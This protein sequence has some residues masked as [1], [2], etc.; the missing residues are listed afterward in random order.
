VSDIFN[1]L[2]TEDLKAQAAWE[3]FHSRITQMAGVPPGRP[4]ETINKMYPKMMYRALQEPGSG[5]WKVSMDIPPRFQYQTDDQWSRAVAQAEQFGTACQRTV[6]SEEEHKQ[7][8]ESGEGWRDNPQEALEWRTKLERDIS[9]AAAERNAEERHMSE[10]A[11]AERDAVEQANMG[12]H[13]AEIPEK[14]RVKR[15]YTRKA[16]TPDAA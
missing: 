14:P 6:H 10:K 13:L 15:K 9:T 7:A 4:Y 2:A 11:I 5:K 12:K 8:R 3:M 1:P 16:Q